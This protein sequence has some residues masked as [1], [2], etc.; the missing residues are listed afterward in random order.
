MI[1]THDMY[2]SV[3]NPHI[4][5][6]SSHTSSFATYHILSYNIHLNT[7]HRDILEREAT[8]MYSR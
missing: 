2:I 5:C 3:S 7:Q 6:T 8:V 4:T 1:C